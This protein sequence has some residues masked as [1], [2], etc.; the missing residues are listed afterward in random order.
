VWPSSSP[1][2]GTVPLLPSLLRATRY[3]LV[4]L[5]YGTSLR[6]SR[7][8]HHLPNWPLPPSLCAISVVIGWPPACRPFSEC[9]M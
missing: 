1:S 9:P 6:R 8:F 3:S 5:R 4:R 7:P 2:K